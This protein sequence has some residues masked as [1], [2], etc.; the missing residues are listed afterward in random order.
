MAKRKSNQRELFE[1]W[2]RTRGQS[3]FARFRNGEYASPAMRERF[4]IWL[5]AAEAQEK[6]L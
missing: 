6:A 5:A 3:R 4:E 2:W 1:Q